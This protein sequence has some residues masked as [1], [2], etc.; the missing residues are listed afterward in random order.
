MNNAMVNRES[1]N[2]NFLKSI[3]VRLDFQ[4]VLNSE[5]ETFLVK[6]KQLLNENGFNRF[7]EK[8]QVK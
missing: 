4:R 7:V 3:I 5:M 1:L 8:I 6:A 2:Y